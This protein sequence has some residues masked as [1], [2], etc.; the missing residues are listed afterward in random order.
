MRSEKKQVSNVMVHM[1]YVL[2]AYEIL[3]RLSKKL[4]LGVDMVPI[5][6]DELHFIIA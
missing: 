2:V 6:A 4:F 5:F 3:K 1:T